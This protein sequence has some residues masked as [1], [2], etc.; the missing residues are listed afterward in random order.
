MFQ[1]GLDRV[2]NFKSEK[3]GGHVASAIKRC[4]MNGIQ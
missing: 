4:L 3:D 1:L 2:D